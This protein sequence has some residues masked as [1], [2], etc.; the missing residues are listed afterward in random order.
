VKGLVTYKTLERKI[1]EIRGQKT[2]LDRDLAK[3]YNVPTKV[4][5][6]AVKRNIK[7][8]PYDFMFILTADEK[9]E[10]VT[11][12]DRFKTLKHSTVTPHAFTE[13]GVAMLSTVLNS[14]KAIR[15][16]IGIMRVFVNIRRM[17]YLDRDII[18]SKLN[19]LGKENKAQHRN[20]IKTIIEIANKS[21]LPTGTQLISPEKPFINRKIFW[22]II[23]S[24]SKHIYWI[25]KYFS[26]AGFELLS[27]S[28]NFKNIK[29]IYILM[30]VDKTNEKLKNI[31]KDF[32]K[33]M[34]SKNIICELRVITDKK[35]ISSIHDRWII[36]KNCCFNV[37]ST[38][39]ILRGQYSEI[40]KT[41]NKPPFMEWWK[42]SKDIITDWNEM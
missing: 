10:L 19:Q 9:N 37:P 3:L 8:F 36:S 12:C 5:N 17:A 39:T 15:V 24:F 25:D 42:K 4:L 16:N 14:E 18:I 30:S 20:T 2:M 35:V 32:K 1:F 33:E 13:Q 40:K 26:K 31:Y 11:N 27:E 22:D 28:L 21:I 34:K 29:K 7:R 38:D 6:Q 23:K 41:S